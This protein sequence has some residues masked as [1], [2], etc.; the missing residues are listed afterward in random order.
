[1]K[2]VKIKFLAERIG[3]LVFGLF[4]GLLFLEGVCR[5][6]YPKPH[7]F[8]HENEHY[9]LVFTPNDE[10]LYSMP[11][12]APRHKIKINSKGLRDIE[13]LYEKPD[14]IIRILILGD[15]YAAALE[16]PLEKTFPRLLEGLLN[17]QSDYHFEVI[18]ASSREVP[19]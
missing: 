5:F 2:R 13:H 9:G 10:G 16:I 17:E 6:L 19:C 1:L 7:N 15:S 18:N 8:Y 4:I 12:D 11:P 3:L 14:N